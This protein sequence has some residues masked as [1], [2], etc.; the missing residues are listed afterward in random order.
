[1]KFKYKY[2]HLSK[3]S[4]LN[5]TFASCDNIGK[6]LIM[7]KKIT[8]ILEYNELVLKKSVVVTITMHLIITT[9]GTWKGACILY[10]QHFFNKTEVRNM[11]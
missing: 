9:V 4:N 7:V 6:M 5:F 1:M 11:R 8:I 2:K 3:P 10:H